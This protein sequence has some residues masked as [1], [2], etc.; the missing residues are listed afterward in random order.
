MSYHL[1]ALQKWGFVE[2][3]EASTDGRERPWR[4]IPGGWRVDA[5]PDQASATA[6]DAVVATMLRRI[7]VDLSNWFERER[8]QSDA[9]R[10]VATVENRALWMTPEE[11]KELTALHAEFVDRRRGRTAANH[12]EGARRIRMVSVVVPLQFE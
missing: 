1:R 2:R 7:R 4:S 11:A 6:A 3:A 8:T 12:P 10:D 5:M 9:W